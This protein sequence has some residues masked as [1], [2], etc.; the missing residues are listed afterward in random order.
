M[1]GESP[2]VSRKSVVQGPGLI[3]TFDPCGMPGRTHILITK[4]STTT[5]S[6]MCFK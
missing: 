6:R 3:G 2:A 5:H 1:V 4:V